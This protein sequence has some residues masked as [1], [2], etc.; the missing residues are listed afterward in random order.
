MKGMA[1]YRKQGFEEVSRKEEEIEGISL[2]VVEME[3]QLHR[4]P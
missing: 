3:K 4:S 2:M 1:F